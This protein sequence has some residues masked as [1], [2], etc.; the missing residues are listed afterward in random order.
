M[1]R[2]E[3][4]AFVDSYPLVMNHIRETIKKLQSVDSE[5]WKTRQG[6]INASIEYGWV[7]VAYTYASLC[8]L[9]EGSL[10]FKTDW[11]FLS[12]ED[13]LKEAEL[14]KARRTEERIAKEEM[15]RKKIEE[16][17]EKRDYEQYLRLKEKYGGKD[18]RIPR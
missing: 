9:Q 2:E 8:Y 17:N 7:T 18:F 15:D 16:E 3:L 4:K 1:G 13:L 14:D 5:H 11:L 10:R 6:I 12:E